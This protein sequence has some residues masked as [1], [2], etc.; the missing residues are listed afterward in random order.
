MNSIRRTVGA[1]ALV[2]LILCSLNL[3]HP[4]VSS[5]SIVPWQKTQLLAPTASD[6]AVSEPSVLYENGLWRMWYRVGWGNNLQGIYYATSSDGIHWTKSG[7]VTND[8]NAHV[9]RYNSTTLL[10]YAHGLITQH[11]IDGIHWY[12]FTQQYG[13][14]PN[15]YLNQ[16]DPYAEGAIGNTEPLK[17]PNGTYLMYYDE[18]NCNIAPTLSPNGPCSTLISSLSYAM[19][20]VYGATTPD[21]IHNWTRMP[22]NP[23]IGNLDSGQFANPNVL[24]QNGVFYAFTDFYSG[25]IYE[26][27]ET[28]ANGIHF[29]NPII[30]PLLVPDVELKFDPHCNQVGDAWVITRSQGIY[31]FYDEDANVAIGSTKSYASIW[32]AFLPDTTLA[33]LAAKHFTNVVPEFQITL[34]IETAT[35]ASLFVLSRRFPVWKKKGD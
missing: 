30:D 8:Y 9:V 23:L 20:A 2:L 1:T 3:V 12:N 25:G 29:T 28:S 27:L 15:P 35:F 6:Q 11:S 17:L 5:S 24:Y 18:L 13:L 19:W 33:Q 34:V 31:L 7:H 21:G 14:T 32:L 26:T 22:S 16:T 4:Q 10:M